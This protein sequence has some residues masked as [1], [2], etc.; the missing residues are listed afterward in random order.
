[1][2]AHVSWVIL[3]ISD[4]ILISRKFTFRPGVKPGESR[5]TINPVNALDAGALGSGFVRAKTK[6]L[7]NNR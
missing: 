6:Y 2:S 4:R 7:K 1:M 5:S 3:Y